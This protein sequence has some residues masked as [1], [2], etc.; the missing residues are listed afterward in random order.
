MH[1]LPPFRPIAETHHPSTVRVSPI[2]PSE[3]TDVEVYLRR[4]TRKCLTG[5]VSRHL[6]EIEAQESICWDSWEEDSKAGQCFEECVAL[7]LVY[8]VEQ[9]EAENE[10]GEE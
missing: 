10:S 8:K 5:L 7:E 6:V 4:Q 2:L 9:G 3:P 1:G